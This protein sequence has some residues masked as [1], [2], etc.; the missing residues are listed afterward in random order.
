MVN[1]IV[2]HMYGYYFFHNFII[3]NESG[4]I[5]TLAACGL[6]LGPWFVE[7]GCLQLL[8]VDHDPG[9]KLLPVIAHDLELSRD[10]QQLGLRC[11]FNFYCE[12]FHLLLYA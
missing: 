9:A 1:D 7:L 4:H 12:F 2:V 11:M 8:A 5:V 6:T 10:G 3:S